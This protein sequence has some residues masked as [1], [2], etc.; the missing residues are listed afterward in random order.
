MKGAE[1]LL[2]IM[3]ELQRYIEILHSY[4]D[5]A[6]EFFSHVREWINKI[7]DYVGRGIDYLVSAVGGRKTDH[8]Q[9]ADDYLFV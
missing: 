2:N 4:V 5:R 6:V 8:L 1:T 3:D 7:I 9:V